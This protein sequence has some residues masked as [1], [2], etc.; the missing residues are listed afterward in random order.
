MALHRS[1][2][3]PSAEG[4]VVEIIGALL[5]GDTA[6]IIVCVG[7]SGKITSVVDVHTPVLSCLVPTL[8]TGVGSKD[9]KKTKRGTGNGEGRQG[10]G[11]LGQ[12]G[13]DGGALAAEEVGESPDAPVV[14]HQPGGNGRDGQDLAGQVAVNAAVEDGLQ[15]V[16]EA[17]LRPVLLPVVVRVDRAAV[18]A[19]LFAIGQVGNILDVAEGVEAGGR[20]FVVQLG[21]RPHIGLGGKGLHTRGTQSEGCCCGG[22]GQEAGSSGDHAAGDFMLQKKD[23][24]E[25]KMCR[26]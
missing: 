18:L 11:E 26:K 15:V 7:H 1:D 25:H 8:I 6:V 13:K 22:G 24:S 23:F 9:K 3:G 5:R 20:N 10:E 19:L 21:N 14:E 16:D 2:E 4:N 12:I 17:V